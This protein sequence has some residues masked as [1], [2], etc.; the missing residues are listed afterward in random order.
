MM[1]A[2]RQGLLREIG[3]ERIRWCEQRREDGA[4]YDDEDGRRADEG[5]RRSADA[6]ARILKE[7]PRRHGL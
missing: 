4:E 1:R 3:R 5:A 6:T 7:R 2:G